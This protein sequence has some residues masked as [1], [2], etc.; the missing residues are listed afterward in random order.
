MHQR[1]LSL[2]L[3]IRAVQKIYKDINIFKNIVKFVLG[4]GSITDNES[5]RKKRRNK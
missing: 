3:E 4:T 1:T 5:N 2:I